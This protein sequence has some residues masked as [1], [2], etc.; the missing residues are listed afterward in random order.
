[1]KYHWSVTS[2]HG[3]SES[4]QVESFDELLAAL[5]NWSARL[6]KSI[7]KIEL[8]AIEKPDGTLISPQEQGL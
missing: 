8:I 2:Y 7:V 4:V 3:F 5:T 1:M 6:T